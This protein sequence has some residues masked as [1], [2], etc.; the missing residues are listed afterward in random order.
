[1]NVIEGSLA[2]IYIG[3]IEKKQSLLV[4]SKLENPR[5]L[6]FELLCIIA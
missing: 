6:P 5:E 2:Q 3:L 1:M 4:V